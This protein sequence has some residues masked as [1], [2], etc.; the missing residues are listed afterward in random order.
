M[1][2]WLNTSQKPWSCRCSGRGVQASRIVGNFEL[3]LPL[4]STTL[5]AHADCSQQGK[6][7]SHGTSQAMELNNPSA[8]TLS[9]FEIGDFQSG[10]KLD[11]PCVTVYFLSC[12]CRFFP[13]EYFVTNYSSRWMR[14]SR[15]KLLQTWCGFGQDQGA[16][17]PDTFT[18]YS[19][20]EKSW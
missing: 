17:I 9:D 7:E 4:H 14:S 16:A 2:P 12:C 3:S 19:A 15:S 13:C 5:S 1:C 10:G 8:K 20:A 11:M 6:V 18:P